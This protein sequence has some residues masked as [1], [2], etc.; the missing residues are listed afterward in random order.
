MSTSFRPNVKHK[1]MAGEVAPG[2]VM[3]FGDPAYA[4]YVDKVITGGRNISIQGTVN[5]GDA[6]D[7]SSRVTII[8]DLFFVLSRYETTSEEETADAVHEDTGGTGQGQV[9][10]PVRTDLDPE[11]GPGISRD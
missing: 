3:P 5:P 2:M 9:Q 10:V 11:A 6:S 7:E 4:L 1:I 8:I